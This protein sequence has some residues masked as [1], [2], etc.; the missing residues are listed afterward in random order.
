[1]SYIR[2]LILG[3][4]AAG[5]LVVLVA[6]QEPAPAPTSGPT[7]TP[8]PSPTPVPTPTRVPTPT[9]TP[10]PTADEIAARSASAMA[11]L[12]SA[13]LRLDV[14]GGALEL[15][16]GVAV[17]EL[18][19]AIARPDRLQLKGKALVMGSVVDSQV[20][21]VG[22]Q[23]FVQDPFSETWQALSPGSSG[24]EVL[25][26]FQVPAVFKQ[27]KGLQ[28]LGIE[29]LA[30]TPVYHLRGTVEP[31]QT[32]ALGVGFVSD[33]PIQAEVWIGA[34]DGLL[35]KATFVVAGASGPVTAT[36][37][38]FGFDEPVKIEAPQTE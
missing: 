20:I 11:A 9:P 33:Q 38:L 19:G 26:P 37:T 29:S 12:R 17:T 13:K 21:K 16:P 2:L 8:A 23:V 30:G 25:D 32:T 28:K 4:C 7:A 34:A 5:S 15:A 35:R 31:A 27:A 6:C 3:L 1:M 24:L 22:K 10:E 14:A 36:L 18:E